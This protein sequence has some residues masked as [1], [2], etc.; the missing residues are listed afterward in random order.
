MIQY[1]YGRYGRE[2][3]ALTATVITYCPRSAIRD[4]GRALGLSEAELGRVAGNLQWWDGSQVAPERI[5][6]AGFD[7]ASPVMCRLLTL[8]GELIGFPRHLSQHVGGFVIA[9]EPL[10]QLVPIENAAMPDRTIIQWDKNDL[11]EMGFAQG[12]GWGLACCR[13]PA[14]LPCSGSTR[15]VTLPAHGARAK[16]LTVYDGSAG[17]TPGRFPVESRAQMACGRCQGP[18]YYTSS[19]GGH[20]CQGPIRVPWHPT[21]AGSNKEE[22]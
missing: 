4:V 10:W 13:H 8:A 5:R 15:D 3:A 20:R 22:R 17:R 6:E 9:E 1:I 14:P 16:T 11:D 2:R 19:R 21:C 18:F 12:R 7:P